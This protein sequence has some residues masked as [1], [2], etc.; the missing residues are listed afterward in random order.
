MNNGESFA[1][2]TIKEP[3]YREVSVHED[4]ERH[5]AMKA[6]L[7]PNLGIGRNRPLAKS[8]PA[9]QEERHGNAGPIKGA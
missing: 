6:T 1:D 7:H 4:R 2:P 8:N 5:C 9:S 3:F